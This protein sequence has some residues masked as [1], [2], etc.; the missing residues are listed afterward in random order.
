MDKRI[1]IQMNNKRSVSGIL[2]GYDAFM[3]LVLDDAIEETS[4]V[5]PSIGLVVVRGNSIQ[6]VECLDRI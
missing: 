4:Q 1:K 2:K 6:I 5:K 3:N